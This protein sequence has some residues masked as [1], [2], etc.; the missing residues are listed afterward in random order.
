[1]RIEIIWWFKFRYRN[2]ITPSLSVNMCFNYGLRNSLDVILELRTLNPFAINLIRLKMT[3]LST[4]M[5]TVKGSDWHRRKSFNI[6]FSQRIT[7]KTP[8]THILIPKFIHIPEN[9]S[10]FISPKAWLEKEYRLFFGPIKLVFRGKLN[11]CFT[12]T[13]AL[14]SFKGFFFCPCSPYVVPDCL[15]PPIV[16]AFKF[17]SV[18]PGLFLC[19]LLGALD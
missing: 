8:S 17:E 19:L 10:I 2:Y 3:P 5:A 14:Y 18:N 13:M 12:L 7:R 15:I 1:M 16:S 4:V 11:S 6:I 9:L